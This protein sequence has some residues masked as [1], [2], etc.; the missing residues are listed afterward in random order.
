MY[1]F[2]ESTFA[3]TLVSFLKNILRCPLKNSAELITII[4]FMSDIL[5]N[6]VNIFLDSK[7][8]A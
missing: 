3:S 7:R 4:D 6:G 8:P 1:Y 5:S 2:L